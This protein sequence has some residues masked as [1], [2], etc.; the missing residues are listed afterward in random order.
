MSV[1]RQP[2]HLPSWCF[3]RAR[4]AVIRG[5]TDW[6]LLAEAVDRKIEDQTDFV[7]LVGRERSSQ[8]GGTVD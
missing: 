7:P 4:V 3:R 2:S 5:K 6:P 8:G 1:D